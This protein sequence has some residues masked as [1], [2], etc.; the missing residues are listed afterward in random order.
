MSLVKYN[1]FIRALLFGHAYYEIPNHIYIQQLILDI[2]KHINVKEIVQNG[3]LLL[4]VQLI[5]RDIQ[6]ILQYLKQGNNGFEPEPLKLKTIAAKNFFNELSS[7]C[8]GDLKFGVVANSHE[9][10]IARNL[11]TLDDAIRNES[12]LKLPLLGLENVTVTNPFIKRALILYDL[13]CKSLGRLEDPFSFVLAF[14]QDYVDSIHWKTKED[15]EALCANAPRN[16]LAIQI[17]NIVKSTIY[18]FLNGEEHFFLSVELKKFLQ[19]INYI[20]DR[21]EKVESDNAPP[22]LIDL[23]QRMLALLKMD[24]LWSLETITMPTLNKDFFIVDVFNRNIELEREN[25][26]LK[27]IISTKKI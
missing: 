2:E 8:K 6:S 26:L 24:Y 17:S 27:N 14:Q 1:E 25:A 11:K 20:N 19:N 7:L 15:L 16:P 23:F 3:G 22:K 12:F 9:R 10:Q 4:S 5:E 13:K 21:I 18:K